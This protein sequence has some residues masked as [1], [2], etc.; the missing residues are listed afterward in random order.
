LVALL[1]LILPFVFFVSNSK[2]TRDHNRVDRIVLWLGAPVQFIVVATLDGTS[3]VIRRYI[4]LMNVERDNERLRAE[5]AQLRAVLSTREE[6]RLEN[7]RLRRLLAVRERAPDAPMVSARV[8]GVSPTP[9][10][11]SFRIDRGKNDGIALGAPVVNADGVVGR[12]GAL[13]DGYAD[14][15]ML[16]DANSSTDV[17]VQRTRARAR[18]R[19]TGSNGRI[20]I[21]VQYLAR[22]DDVAPGD[23][24]ITS[25]A[26]GSFPK[27]LKVG[28]IEGVERRGF[29]LYQDARA[30]PS[31]DFE[32]IEEV[33]VMQP[34]WP[35]ETDFEP[36][37][38][39][40]SP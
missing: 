4:T 7:E 29:G 38:N 31:V 25:G 24:L 5:N 3:R 23:V 8:I 12:V 28:V 9:L 14:V 21:E 18:V 1:L 35:Q 13:N 19:G 32:R 15:M 36:A 37:K 10:F 16:V 40:A 30:R 22:T 27:G 34:P 2:S 26:G 33:L 39:G 17:L 6:Q 11:R 20:G